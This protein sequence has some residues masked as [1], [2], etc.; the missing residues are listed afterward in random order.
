LILLNKKQYKSLASETPHHSSLGL[1]LEL[2]HQ[3]FAMRWVL[4]ILSFSVE[5]HQPAVSGGRAKPFLACNLKKLVRAMQAVLAILRQI[6][7]GQSDRAGE[8]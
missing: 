1:S 6:R 4:S 2:I 7:S 3:V 5:P 8:G